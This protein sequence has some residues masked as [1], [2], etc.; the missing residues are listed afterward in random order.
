MKGPRAF[1]SPCRS[2]N[3]QAPRLHRARVAGL[4]TDTD[5]HLWV[6]N[7]LDEQSSEWSVFDP[8]GRWLGTMSLP[9]ARVTWI[10]RDRIVGVLTDPDIGVESV[11]VHRLN[12]T[13]PR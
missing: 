12:R 4:I 11:V 5:G 13:A 1:S 3:H 2:P 8:E 9:V 7:R 10:T 6:A